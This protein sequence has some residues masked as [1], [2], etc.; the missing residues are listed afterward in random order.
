MKLLLLLDT[1]I[2]FVLFPAI[3]RARR[4]LGRWIAVPVGDPLQSREAPR[5]TILVP[6]RNEE[7]SIESC[8]RSLLAQDYPRDRCEIIVLDDGSTDGT[9][10]I[11]QRIA[12]AEPGLTVH[13]G[14]PLPQGWVGKCWA[15]HQA[16]KYAHRQSSFLLF[17]DADTTHEPK[18]LTSAVRFAAAGN[19]DLLS[20]GTGQVLEGKAERL[21]LPTIFSVAMIA[22]GTFDEVNDPDRRDVSKANGQFILIARDA[23]FA[24]DGH[25][26]VR[27]EIVEDFELARR[28]KRSGYRIYFADGRQLVRTRGYR[29][30][31][32]I[33]EGFSKNVFNEARKQPGGAVLPLL[34]LPF[35]ALGPALLAAFALRGIHRSIN[36]PGV[37]LLLQAGLQGTVLLRAGQLAALAVGLPANYGLSQPFATLFLWAVLANGVW[38]SLSG[39]SVVWKDRPMY[40]SSDGRLSEN[41]SWNRGGKPAGA[42]PKSLPLSNGGR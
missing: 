40:L 13:A 37:L 21:L 7:R 41:P 26:G 35:M 4:S 8:V 27:G 11:L 39:K 42:R 34:L 36:R 16:V 30:L 18:T 3:W 29:S 23:Y 15:L 24:I 5:V 10:S 2:S 1:L 12:E 19:I 17:T 14:K 38:R 9:S 22:N 28:A 33:W 20:L 31:R 6:C 25:E 32:E